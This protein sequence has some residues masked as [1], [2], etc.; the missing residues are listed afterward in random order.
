MSGNDERELKPLS[1]G[2]FHLVQALKQMGA[3]KEIIQ[4]VIKI[5]NQ[6][7]L[8]ELT[9]DEWDKKFD[10]VVVPELERLGYR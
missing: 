3:L 4:T 5:G 8:G 7:D 9:D 1:K 10:S 6:H 2:T